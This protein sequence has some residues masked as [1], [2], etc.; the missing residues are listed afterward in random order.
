MH[1]NYYA[2]NLKGKKINRNSAIHNQAIY[3]VNKICELSQ[4][5][6]MHFKAEVNSLFLLVQKKNAKCQF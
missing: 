1:K 4:A 3:P 6:E 2:Q 5:N